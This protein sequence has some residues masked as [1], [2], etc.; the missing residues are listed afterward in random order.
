EAHIDL[1][2]CWACLQGERCVVYVIEAPW[3]AGFFTWCDDPQERAV[4]RY[5]DPTEAIRAG[6]RRA[7]RRGS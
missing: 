6:L 7:A 1:S 3:S 5:L 4:E 2:G